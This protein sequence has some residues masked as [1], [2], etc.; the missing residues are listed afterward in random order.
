VGGLNNDCD[1]LITSFKSN[2]IFP[3]LI[4]FS[5]HYIH[6]QNLSYIR[7]KNYYLGA[8]FAPSTCQGEGVCL[9][10]RADLPYIALDVSQFCVQKFIQICLLKINIREVHF[11][12]L[13]LYRTPLGKFKQFLNVL[14]A[15]LR[16][17]GY[18]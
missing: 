2:N 15:I 8:S 18:V 14:R 16:H 10:V 13:G 1:E 9:F 6:K 7:I 12:V 11:I 4:C 5:K 17:I 3:H